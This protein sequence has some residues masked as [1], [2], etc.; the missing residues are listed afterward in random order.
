MIHLNNIQDYNSWMVSVQGDFT[1]T[2]LS[3][4]QTKGSNDVLHEAA[5]NPDIFDEELIVLD[6]L[7]SYYLH[8]GKGAFFEW[9]SQRKKHENAG[10]SDP[11]WYLKAWPEKVVDIMPY[12]QRTVTQLFPARTTKRPDRQRLTWIKR[13]INTC[14]NSELLRPTIIEALTIPEACDITQID[15]ISQL[16]EFLRVTLAD[17]IYKTVITDRLPSALIVPPE[18]YQFPHTAEK[19]RSVS[20]FYPNRALML[21]FKACK[22]AKKAKTLPEVL[23]RTLPDLL[24]LTALP[25]FEEWKTYV[26]KTNHYCSMWTRQVL[27]APFEKYKLFDLEEDSQ[28][29]RITIKRLYSNPQPEDKQ[30]SKPA[31]QEAE[32]RVAKEEVQEVTEER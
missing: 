17:Q 20:Y 4:V 14:V 16:P 27:N 29:Y 15:S 3:L 12:I 13:F 7:L 9:Q 19:R 6:L 8:S 26:H 18:L 30:P 23:S 10:T 24:K 1:Y 28:N 25:T 32:D 31:V 2:G 22:E 11:T 5:K 21:H